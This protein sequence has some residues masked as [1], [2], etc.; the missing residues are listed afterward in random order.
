MG[1]F[2]KLSDQLRYPAAYAY[3]SLQS[4]MN[5]FRSL[6][7]ADSVLYSSSYAGQ[8]IVLMA[9]FQKG[10][11]RNDVVHFLRAAKEAGLYVVCVNTLKIK[12]PERYSD[13]IDCYVEKYNYG[14]DFGSYKSGFNYLYSSGLAEQCPRMMLVNDSVFFS[15]KHNA[16]FLHEMFD[17]SVEALGAT[18]NYEIEHHLGSFCIALSNNVLNH[19]RLKK[20]WKDYKCTDVRPVVIKTGE[21]ELSKTLKRIVS[22]PNNFRSLYDIGRASE[23]LHGSDEV[24]EDIARLSRNSELLHWPRFSFSAVSKDVISKYLH[25]PAAIAGVSALNADFDSLSEVEVHYADSLSG[26]SEFVCG[27]VTNSS[28]AAGSIRSTVKGEVISNF[29]G[30]F[31][32]GSQI[33]QNGIFLHRIGLPIIKLDGVYRGM[34]VSKDIENIALDLE[35]DQRGEFRWIMYSRPFGGDVLIGWKRAAFLRGLI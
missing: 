2:Q 22:S 26:F 5:W 10:E 30:C 1:I 13:I 6:G 12:N 31:A 11:I 20:Y 8:K 35:P 15:R 14:R 19:P 3:V 29:I 32:H 4:R 28:S 25:S 16:Q 27:A 33:H 18:E 23:L 7:K 24:L 9:L 34:F 21:M 17:S